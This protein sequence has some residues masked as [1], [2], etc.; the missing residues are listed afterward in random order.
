MVSYFFCPSV[1]LPQGNIGFKHK[2]NDHVINTV[3]V[4]LQIF[5]RSK[6]K[7]TGNKN[8]LNFAKGS[9]KTEEE[10]TAVF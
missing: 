6:R 3:L 9:E 1:L 2:I 5:W 10:W 7:E 8:K 4:L